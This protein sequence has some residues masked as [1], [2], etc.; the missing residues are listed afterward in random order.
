MNHL[1]EE[2][3]RRFGAM[4]EAVAAFCRQTGIACQPGCG[5]CCKRDDIETTVEEMMPMAAAIIATG[6]ETPWFEGAGTAPVGECPV[7]SPTLTPYGGHCLFYPY[8]PAICRLFGYAAKRDKQGALQP[9][10]CREVKNARPTVVA[11]L[12]QA[13]AGGLAMPVFTDYTLAM[14]DLFGG[15][16]GRRIP[17]GYALRAAIEKVGLYLSLQPASAPRRRTRRK[18]A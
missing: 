15:N 6:R 3:T 9:V 2:M 4:D 13:L 8:R 1:I 17:I 16:G 14:V 10:I 7:Y 12:Q 11:E 18:A 5:A